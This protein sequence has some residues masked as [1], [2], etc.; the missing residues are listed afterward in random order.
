MGT[1]AA[2]CNAASPDHKPKCQHELTH[3]RDRGDIGR[4]ALHDCPDDGVEDIAEASDSEQETEQL[5]DITRSVGQ[6][7]QDEQA[8]TK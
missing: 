7:R 3:A 2:Q 5:R 8:Q 4:G 6:V 1:R